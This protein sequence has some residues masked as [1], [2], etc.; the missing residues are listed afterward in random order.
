MGGTCFYRHH[1]NANLILF[2]TPQLRSME[3]DKALVG[4]VLDLEYTRY[5]DNPFARNNT[6][7]WSI[8]LNQIDDISNRILASP[9]IR[10]IMREHNDGLW[11]KWGDPEK[12]IAPEEDSEWKTNL[13][14]IKEWSSSLKDGDVITFRFNRKAPPGWEKSYIFKAVENSQGK[15]LPFCSL[16]IKHDG[17]KR[18][19]ISRF[20]TEG[21]V[22]ILP[23][24][25]PSAITRKD[26][27]EALEYISLQLF[28]SSIHTRDVDTDIFYFDIKN[29][30]YMLVTM[31]VIVKKRGKPDE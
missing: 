5:P 13:E 11:K 23:C 29:F 17:I 28:L 7:K 20:E 19:G 14:H 12:L 31:R 1:E 6:Q 9:E 3:R 24:D 15:S 18:F 2:R 16:K 30:P 10:E 8:L 4:S 26:V 25:R 27:D 22:P 21:F